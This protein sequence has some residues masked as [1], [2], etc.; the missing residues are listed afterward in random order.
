[1]RNARHH[2]LRGILFLLVGL[3]TAGFVF[4]VWGFGT[5]DSFER[6]TIDTRFSIR[7]DQ[8]PPKEI[9][10]VAIDDVTTDTI[11]NFVWPY[12]RRL[13]AQVI[14]RISAG[15]PRAIA[16]D[17]QFT[18][19]TNDRDD[20]ALVDSVARAGN[21][22]LTTTET[23]PNGETNILGGNEFLKELGAR[24]ASGLLPTDDEGVIRKVPHTI[25]GLETLG[26]VAVEVATGRQVGGNGFPAWIDYAGEAP[27]FKR[28]S[29]VDVLRKRVP[30]KDFTGKIVVIGPAAPSLQDI[31]ETPVDALMPGGEVQANSIATVLR[32]LPLRSSA[33]ALTVGLILLFSFLVP[34]LSLGF[35]PRSSAPIALLVGALFIVA[36][37]LSFNHGRI[38][39]FVYPMTALALSTVGSMAVGI[40]MTAF[41]REQVRDVF[42]RFVP[43]SVVSEV[44]K[45]TDADLRLGG[46]GV[47]GTVLFTDLRGFTTASEHLTPAEVLDL[48]N[49]HLEEVVGAVLDHGG[50]LVS[51]TGD[52]IF[53]VFG[54]PIEQVNHAQRSFDAAREILKVRLP[55]WNDW[56]AE[57]GFPSG[58]RMG[59][60][61][62]SGP[63]MSGNIGSA[64]RLAYTAMGDTINTA[65]RIEQ[66][67]K[68]A[69]H[70]LLVA[71][72]TKDAL[73]AE[74]QAQLVEL[75]EVEVRGRTS[76]LPLW[77]FP[78]D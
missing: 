20:G 48:I 24:P 22:I 30:S 63:F 51:Y 55:R 5:L 72:S 54:A 8:T 38:V 67:T 45:R 50:T 75:G 73:D 71:G 70:M 43:E 6:Q 64:Q 61:L 65:S 18:E 74:S 11:R 76:K 10:F 37:Q 28:Y 52:G 44:L 27:K 17:I 33:T 29:Y 40:A 12:P 35:R 16:I 21:V 53:A 34:G 60:G 77:G 62:N 15:H 39:S 42:T 4:F 7:G 47:E 49:R 36:V 32:G 57:Q 58:F 1:M 56:L 3:S 9:V 23:L 26:V 2:R 46:V 78:E 41:E 59:I 31:H 13:H 25:N 69:G 66:M 68:T 19:R 14:D